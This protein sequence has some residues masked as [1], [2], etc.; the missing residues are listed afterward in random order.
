MELPLKGSLK[1]VRLCVVE[2]ALLISFGPS[3]KGQSNEEV[4]DSGARQDDDGS[5]DWLTSFEGTRPRLESGI[6]RTNGPLNRR[7][8]R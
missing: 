3:A 2:S 8:G 7:G 6:R 1:Y 4:N 5:P